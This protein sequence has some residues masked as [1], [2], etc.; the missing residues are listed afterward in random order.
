MVI[1]PRK[2]LV[3]IFQIFFFGSP[4]FVVPLLICP[5]SVW[6]TWSPFPSIHCLQFVCHF[7]FWENAF[8]IIIQS[9]WCEMGTVVNRGA[10][11]TLTSLALPG[12]ESPRM[13]SFIL[14]YFDSLFLVSKL[15]ILDTKIPLKNE[16]WRGEDSS[17]ST[18][19]H[20]STDMDGCL[21]SGGVGE[22]VK[23]WA[24]SVV[25]Q[26]VSSFLTWQHPAG[27]WLFIGKMRERQSIMASTKANLFWKLVVC[28]IEERFGHNLKLGQTWIE[29]A[30]RSPFFFFLPCYNQGA[31][32]W[33]FKP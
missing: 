27:K 26:C 5:L 1:L 22:P 16:M 32:I 15:F 20:L 8:S 21:T 2:L 11:T 25:I 13:G 29:F 10:T 12:K 7:G 3:V 6:Q 31:F 23:F 14:T 18:E 19:L 24:W 9:V 28:K 33:Y 17:D 30:Y 4:E